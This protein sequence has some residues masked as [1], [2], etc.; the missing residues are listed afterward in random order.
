MLRRVIKMFGQPCQIPRL[1]PKSKQSKMS[2]MNLYKIVS[3]ECLLLT[4]HWSFGTRSRCIAEQ[5]RIWVAGKILRPATNCTV[6]QEK[7]AVYQQIKRTLNSCKCLFYLV[8]LICVHVKVDIE[9]LELEF[10]DQMCQPWRSVFYVMHSKCL[11]LILHQLY[12]NLMW[13]ILNIRKCSS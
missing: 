5:M 11:V 12:E 7:K 4:A 2:E 3:M 1:H 8:H 6:V 9:W 10:R 13:S